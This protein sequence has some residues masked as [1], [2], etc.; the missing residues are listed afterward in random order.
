MLM[1]EA[2]FLTSTYKKN[3]MGKEE[4][5]QIQFQ[6]RTKFLIFSLF[7]EIAYEAHYGSWK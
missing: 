4:V 1:F 7:C 3:L 2:C 5:F 6:Y